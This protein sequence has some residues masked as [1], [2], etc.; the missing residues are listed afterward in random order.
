LRH[1]ARQSLQL[2]VDQLTGRELA[3]VFG[4]HIPLD[5]LV[6]NRWHPDT[7]QCQLSY[8]WRKDVS[9]QERVHHPHTSHWKCDLHAHLPC[10]ASGSN[11]HHEAVLSENQHKN[12]AVGAVAEILGVDSNSVAWGFNAKREVSVSHPRLTSDDMKGRVRQ[13]L[14]TAVPNKT[15]YVE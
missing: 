8:M 11:D 1:N 6:I 13:H 7:C 4:E 15:T 12:A 5:L 9:E 2:K 14:Q 10:I 3:E